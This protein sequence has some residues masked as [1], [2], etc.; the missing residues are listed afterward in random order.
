MPLIIEEQVEMAWK[1]DLISMT[2]DPENTHAGEEE[3]RVSM[4]HQPSPTE[5]VD[6]D[7]RWQCISGWYREATDAYV[8][9][10]CT[11]GRTPA[12]QAAH[13][14]GCIFW[15]MH[16]SRLRKKCPFKLDV[17]CWV[18]FLTRTIGERAPLLPFSIGAPLM[19]ATSVAWAGA[20][21]DTALFFLEKA[22]HILCFSATIT[23]RNQ[24]RQWSSN[25]CLR[26]LFYY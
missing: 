17:E 4:Q 23:Q 2:I 14:P 10:T 1:R 25:G 3:G 13:F 12:G 22:I 24:T 15:I 26:A 7:R 21:R 16:I 20:T 18:S 8:D 9:R 6:G 19:H 5:T 11:Y